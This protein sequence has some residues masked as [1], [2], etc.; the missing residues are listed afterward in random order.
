MSDRKKF[1]VLSSNGQWMAFV[2]AACESKAVSVALKAFPG[3]AIQVR[4]CLGVRTGTDATLLV[5]FEREALKAWAHKSRQAA[6]RCQATGQLLRNLQAV[7]PRWYR[8]RTWAL[9]RARYDAA[10][11]SMRHRKGPEL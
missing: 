5:I 10:R 7:V 9:M 11:K 6:I 1:E 4:P 3:R 8:A 2:Y